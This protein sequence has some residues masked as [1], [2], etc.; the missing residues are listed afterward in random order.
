MSPIPALRIVAYLLRLQQCLPD[1]G[2]DTDSDVFH[3]PIKSG[4]FGKQV[5][6]RYELAAIGKEV[7]SELG[8]GESRDQY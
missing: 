3:V 4:G 2:K 5:I 1:L 7:A 8:V 6:G